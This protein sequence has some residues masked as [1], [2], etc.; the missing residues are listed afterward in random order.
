METLHLHL[1][2]MGPHAVSQ[3]VREAGPSQAQALV[4]VLFLPTYSFSL[5]CSSVELR[6]IS[7]TPSG[8]H[9]FPV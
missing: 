1:K 2:E 7:V 8:G 5:L 3:E 6:R 9:V 4:C